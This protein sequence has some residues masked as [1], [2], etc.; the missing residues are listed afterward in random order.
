MNKTNTRWVR[1]D[2]EEDGI[3][4]EIAD[5]HSSSLAA[6][7]RFI[8]RDWNRKIG[9]ENRNAGYAVTEMFEGQAE[10]DA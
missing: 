10:H 7:I 4:A 2:D 1:L 8:I 5:Y 6:A 9:L 3:V